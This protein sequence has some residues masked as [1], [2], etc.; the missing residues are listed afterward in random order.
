M[1]S[2]F[3]IVRKMQLS[4][5][6][7]F[8]KKDSIYWNTYGYN[9]RAIVAF[10]CGVIPTLPGFIRNVNPGYGIPRGAVSFD[11][12]QTTKRRSRLTLQPR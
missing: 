2:D 9:V 12:A 8:L 4:L 5:G 11:S 7:M 10:V 6:D 3:F 1:L